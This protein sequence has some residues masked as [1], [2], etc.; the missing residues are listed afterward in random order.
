IFFFFSTGSNNTQSVIQSPSSEHRPEG[1][2]VSLH[3]RFTVSFDQYVMSW[4]QQLSNR[5]M[6]E[7]INIHSSSTKTEKGRY[8]V[9]HQK[10]NKAL[11]LTITGLMPIDSGIY[12]CAVRE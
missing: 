10:G 4:F 1:E 9:S 7:I 8:F 3:C 5:K 11:S 2:S 6:T 12:F